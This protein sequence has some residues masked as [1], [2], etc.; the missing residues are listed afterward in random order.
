MTTFEHNIIQRGVSEKLDTAN[1]EY[2]KCKDTFVT[3]RNYLNELMQKNEKSSVPDY[4]SMQK[5]EK[6]G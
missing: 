6:S 4:V 5:K 1:D 3:I 2:T